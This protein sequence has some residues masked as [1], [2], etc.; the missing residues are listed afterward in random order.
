MISGVIMV[1]KFPAPSLFRGD[2][3]RIVIDVIPPRVPARTRRCGLILSEG[4]PII[5]PDF[6]CIRSCDA[7]HPQSAL[8]SRAPPSYITRDAANNFIIRLAAINQ[9][10]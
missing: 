7:A 10:T 5:Q 4:V 6:D 9:L 2:N 3:R 8:R 1:P